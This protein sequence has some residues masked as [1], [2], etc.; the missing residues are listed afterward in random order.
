MIKFT[1]RMEGSVFTQL[2]QESWNDDGDEFIA[3][4]DLQDDETTI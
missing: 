3:S 1:W 4:Y 2:D